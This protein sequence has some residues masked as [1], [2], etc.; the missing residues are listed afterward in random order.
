MRYQNNVKI[1]E[2]MNQHGVWNDSP[3]PVFMHRC[4]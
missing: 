1:V 2:T 4:V 3:A